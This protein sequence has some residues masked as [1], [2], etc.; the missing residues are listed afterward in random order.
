MTMLARSRTDTSLGHTYDIIQHRRHTTTAH[1][2]HALP[3]SPTPTPP[4][5]AVTSTGMAG[6]P[7]R[8]TVILGKNL[9]RSVTSATG[10]NHHRPNPETASLKST[11]SRHPATTDSYAASIQRRQLQQQ[12]HEHGHGQQRQPAG[13]PESSHSYKHD[14]LKDTARWKPHPWTT[15]SSSYSYTS[16]Y[17]S[18]SSPLH[19]SRFPH[20]LDHED[21]E[22]GHGD[23]DESSSEDDDSDSDSDSEEACEEDLKGSSIGAVREWNRDQGDACSQEHSRRHSTHGRSQDDPSCRRQSLA[24]EQGRQTRRQSMGASDAHSYRSLSVTTTTTRRPKAEP[25]YHDMKAIQMR[26]YGHEGDDDD[27][28]SRFEQQA[29]HEDLGPQEQGY[30]DGSGGYYGYYDQSFQWHSYTYDQQP[31]S[32]GSYYEPATSSDAEFS[33]SP[34]IPSKTRSQDSLAK[35]ASLAKA[36]FYKYLNKPASTSSSSQNNHHPL[37]SGSSNLEPTSHHHYQHDFY[38]TEVD[39][40]DYDSSYHHFGSG[41]SFKSSLRARVRL[42]RTKTVLRQVKR[43]LSEALSE[44]TTKAASTLRHDLNLGKKSGPGPV[45]M[46]GMVEMECGSSHGQEQLGRADRQDHKYGQGQ[47]K[48]H[49]RQARR[50]YR[51]QAQSRVH[52]Q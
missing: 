16:A 39:D 52:G 45:R 23:S 6:R 48:A 47:S 12:Q 27:G 28:Y 18:P 8:N 11:N 22:D 42:T 5:A 4:L 10:P 49:R 50:H 17:S 2:H 33:G 26:P 25:L 3:E 9:V 37:D 21:E 20:E 34:T 29:S 43:R 1:T 7:R 30:E 24:Q 46:N 15:A 13:R 44:A 38:E 32:T 35:K 36:K 40:H 19:Q 14:F 31:D 51:S 41:Y